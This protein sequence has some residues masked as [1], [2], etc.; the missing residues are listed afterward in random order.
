KHFHT[1][2]HTQNN[3]Q[4]K[5]FS[6]LHSHKCFESCW[7]PKKF[8]RKVPQAIF[9]TRPTIA[10]A[11]KNGSARCFNTERTI[12]KHERRISCPLKQSYPHQVSFKNSLTSQGL[13]IPVACICTYSLEPILARIL[14]WRYPVTNYPIEAKRV[15]AAAK[16]EGLD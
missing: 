6:Q 4:L 5:Y 11:Q 16:A 1:Y 14:E 13:S 8:W 9:V 12:T 7:M 3:R 10:S 2:F 15:Q